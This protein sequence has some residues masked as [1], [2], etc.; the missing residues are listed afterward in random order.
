MPRCIHVMY[1][2]IYVQM[3][4][5]IYICICMTAHVGHG[6]PEM[7]KMQGNPWLLLKNVPYSSDVLYICINVYMHYCIYIYMYI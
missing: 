5:Y 4:I 6:A 1:K 3:Y 7:L 2:C